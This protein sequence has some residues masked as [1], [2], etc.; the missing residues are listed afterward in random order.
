MLRTTLRFAAL[1]AAHVAAAVEV[2]SLRPGAQHRWALDFRARLEQG[3][4]P[5][6][7]HLTGAWLSTIT[8][9]RP[10]EYDAELRIADAGFAG[11]AVKD[12]PAAALDDLRRRISRPFW[13]TYRAD[14][15]L[16]AIHFYKDVSPTDRNLLQTIATE[17]QLVRPPGSQSAWSLEERD[18]AGAYLAMYAREGNTIV[19][20]KVK[21][22]YTD[23]VAGASADALQVHV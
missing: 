23:G 4:R 2:P 22:I 11:D 21:Y 1:A 17:A 5:V 10:A 15:A 14:G 20:R 3:A 7:V 16:L 8:A 19:K 12:V 6:E 13:A 9:V 18:G